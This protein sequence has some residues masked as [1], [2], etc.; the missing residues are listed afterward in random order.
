MQDM[1]E[2]YIREALAEAKKAYNKKEVPI[3]CVIV[4]KDKVIARAHNLREGKQNALYHAE[5]LAI[6][7]ACKKLKS[8]RL[9]ECDLYVTLE[10]CAMCSG[11]ILQSKVGNVY[12]GAYDK[13]AGM[14]GS[15]FNIFDIKF[16]YDPILKGGILEEECSN[17]IKEFF[18]ELRKEK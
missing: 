14:A 9:D 2:L 11:A 6:D 15:R 13:K 10:P 1:K 12:F 4:Y 3:G 18:K 8:W 5:I 7:K 17:L 16:N